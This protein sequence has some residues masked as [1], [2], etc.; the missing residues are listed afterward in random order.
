M[1]S[2]KATEPSYLEVTKGLK[3]WLVTLDH[4][5][6]GCMYLIGILAALMIGG[7]FA[8]LVRIEL[9]APGETIS[10]CVPSAAI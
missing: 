10:I 7:F 9:F 5:R 8:L 2:T 6:I 4:K 3:N 1:A